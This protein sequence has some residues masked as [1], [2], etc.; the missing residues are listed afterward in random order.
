MENC[1]VKIGTGMGQIQSGDLSDMCL[2]NIA[3]KGW[4]SLNRVKNRHGIACY[5]RYRDDIIILADR[6]NERG[7]RQFVAK[8][9][10]KANLITE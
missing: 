2:Y 3:E 4:A 10:S 1:L 9:V 8:L 7:W 5:I 6:D